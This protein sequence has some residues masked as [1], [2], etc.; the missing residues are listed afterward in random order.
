MLENSK[1][2]GQ[3][4]MARERGQPNESNGLFQRGVD[5]YDSGE[6]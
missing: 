1:H 6:P 4:L 5:D 3:M 2:K